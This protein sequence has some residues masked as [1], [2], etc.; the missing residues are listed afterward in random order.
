MFEKTE[1]SKKRFWELFMPHLV[2]FGFWLAV[3]SFAFFGWQSVSPKEGD[4]MNLAQNILYWT[5]MIIGWL[6]LAML[7]YLALAWLFNIGIKTVR[8]KT[9]KETIGQMK[10][11]RKAMRDALEELDIKIKEAENDRTNKSAKQ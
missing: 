8:A 7:V 2:T 3:S 1:Y 10:I 11:K 5:F 6:G 4:T 9:C